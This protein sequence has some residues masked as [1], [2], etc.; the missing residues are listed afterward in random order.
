LVDDYLKDNLIDKDKIIKLSRKIQPKSKTGHQ[1]FDNKYWV[2]VDEQT[3]NENPIWPK[4]KLS[5][6]F[7][8]MLSQEFRKQKLGGVFYVVGYDLYR[9]KKKLFAIN[10]D[11]DSINSIVNKVKQIY[12]SILI[13]ERT[14]AKTIHS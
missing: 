2:S 5:D 4:S 7:E 10:P 12:E 3:L 11:S 1:V 14:T 13:K 8:F 6:K 9:N